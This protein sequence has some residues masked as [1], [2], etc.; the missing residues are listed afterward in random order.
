MNEGH[1]ENSK[2]NTLEVEEKMYLNVII[3]SYVCVGYGY[4]FEKY[5]NCI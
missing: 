1:L 2:N 4:V 3:Y 5:L